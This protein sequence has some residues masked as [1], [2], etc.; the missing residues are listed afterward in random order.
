M[1]F[2]LLRQMRGTASELGLIS[3][4]QRRN[5]EEMNRG[6][7]MTVT[8]SELFT[9]RTDRNLRIDKETESLN[10]GQKKIIN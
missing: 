9:Q 7:E 2:T 5:A 6:A 10:F 1:C 4:E 3:R 8:V